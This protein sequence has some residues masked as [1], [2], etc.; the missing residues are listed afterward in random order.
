MKI[1]LY[2][3]W[4]Y[5]KS[6]VERT[7]LE[8]V[9][10]STHEF[11]IFTNHYDKKG[12]FPEFKKLK[13]IELRKVPVQRDMWSVIRAAAIILLQKI[14]LNG[15]DTLFVHSDGLGDLIVLRNSS[16][17]VLCY[18][19]TP[20]RPVF[21]EFYR[22][23]TLKDSPYKVHIVF[24]V[25]SSLFKVFDKILWRRYAYVFFNSHETLR[26][27][28]NGGLLN[29][30]NEKCEVLHPGVNSSAIKPTWNYKP[31]F[32]L[33][34]RIMWTKNIE[35]ALR[36]FKLFKKNNPDLARFKVII[37]GQVDKKSN[38]Y[39]QKIKIMSKNRKD[40]EFLVSPTDKKMKGFYANAWAVLSTSFNEDFGITLLE[41]NAFGK[42]VIALNQG[43]PK[44]SQKD[45]VTG[46][47]VDPN[48][49]SY[50]EAL[51]NL[52][53]NLKLTKKMG[54]SAR[55]NSTRYDLDRFV[56]RIDHILQKTRFLKSSSV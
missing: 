54:K 26:R 15:F 45:C 49:E 7:I 6:G 53:F 21:D 36:A 5:L 3:P 23:H 17:P 28:R 46:F 12:T 55:Q 44:D 2:Y 38:S 20:L 43:G 14:N 24:L 19:H 35:F 31:Y 52:A 9:K 34:G 16:V 40:I 29:S 33:P 10:R 25:L 22:E 27:A 32:F 30:V 13:V 1:A 41:G 18:C 42:P 51:T 11:T 48:K 50:A 4:I 56:K 37:A 39:F 8:I 47:L